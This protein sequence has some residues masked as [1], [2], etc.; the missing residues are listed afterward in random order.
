MSRQALSQ[1]LG[2]LAAQLLIKLFEQ[3]IERIAVK[4]NT[5]EVAPMWASIA[6]EFGAVW[7]ADASTV[8]AV[9]KHLGQLQ[10]KTGAIL[11]G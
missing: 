3:V 8:E 9:K 6:E 5:R 7:I 1:R 4:K 10:E 2:S 11:G